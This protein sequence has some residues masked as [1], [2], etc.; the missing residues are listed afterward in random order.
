MSP[1]RRWWAARLKHFFVM[2]APVCAYLLLRPH[3]QR[4]FPASV[5]GLLP[6]A[7]APAGRCLGEAGSWQS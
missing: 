1:T 6:T 3:L 5:A 7:A 2:A 4:T